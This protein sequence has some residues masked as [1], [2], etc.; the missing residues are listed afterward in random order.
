MPKISVIV[1]VY[2]VE[3]Y[4]NRCVHSLINQTFDDIEIILVDDGSPDNSGSMCDVF[5]KQDPRIK[6][7]HQKNKGLS[8]ARNAGLLI[9]RGDYISFV[10]SDDIVSNKFLE[11]LLKVMIQQNA[12][13]VSCG[14]VDVYEDKIP[15]RFKEVKS[16]KYSSQT[17]LKEKALEYLVEN[18][19]IFQTVWDKLYKREI[20]HGLSFEEGKLHED[21]FFT[22]KVLLKCKRVAYVS[23]PLYYYFHRK[24]SIMETFSRG[25][26]D[27]LQ[28]RYER[29][30][31]I[32]QNY[33]ALL[34]ESKKS[35]E[36]PC[37][38]MMQRL[39]KNK[40]FQQVDQCKK[41]LVEYY[42]KCQFSK[43]E[44]KSFPI[45]YSVNFF[46][47]N[48]SLELCARIRNLMRRRL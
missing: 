37:I 3:Q 9:A 41:I 31:Y 16:M 13:I 11:I 29:H 2:K 12:D 4:L 36:F 43:K 38:I 30:L 33:P 39:L 32:E 48:I 25:R 8:G 14:R 17:I 46:V 44:L 26:L 45:R 6:V 19:I 18:K 35:I 27:F 42:R 28:A 40:K 15:D 22:W 1:P 34:L 24:G 21:E 23:A 47:A 5:A 7:I 20:I 10:D